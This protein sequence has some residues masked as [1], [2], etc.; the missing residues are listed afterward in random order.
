MADYSRSRFH[1]LKEQYDGGFVLLMDD[2]GKLWTYDDDAQNLASELG[3]EARQNRKGLL[4]L[5][6][7]PSDLDEYL[8]QDI[9][10]EEGAF[11]LPFAE[12]DIPCT[13]EEAPRLPSS[14]L[15]RAVLLSDD[16]EERGITIV[17]DVSEQNT[18]KG[19][20]W[21][22]RGLSKAILHAL[23][24]REDHFT[25]RDTFYIIDSIYYTPKYKALL[26][27]R[28]HFLDAEA[29]PKT[30]FVYKLGPFGDHEPVTA[31]F[32]YPGSPS[33]A[34]MTVFYSPHDNIYFVNQKTYDDFRQQYGL[35]YV[36]LNPA[37]GEPF[38]SDPNMAEESI[39]HLYGYNVSAADGLTDRERQDILARLMD[40]GIVTK[41]KIMRHVEYMI[42]LREKDPVMQTAVMKWRRDLAFVSTYRLS[43]QRTIWINHVTHQ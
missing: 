18:H 23:D 10:N 21:E 31:L 11:L 1:A 13:D 29:E 8:L 26:E 35:P 41:E 17:S 19:I 39:L 38:P 30:L 24:E 37:P 34:G 27:H 20:F 28:L 3:K 25:F 6:I 14:A 16:E 15:L 36:S 9:D 5:S 2:Y 4:S 42:F 40:Y 22:D 7:Q 33:P 32:F 43:D 12:D